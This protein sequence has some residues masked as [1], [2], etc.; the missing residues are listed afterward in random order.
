MMLSHPSVDAGLAVSGVYELAPIRGTGLNAKLQLKDEEIASLSPLR[1]PVVP[2][3]LA[4][5]YGAKE[6]PA[7]VGDSRS[8]HA[9]RVQQKASGPLIEIAGADHFTIL[10][11]L[12]K[13]HGHLVKAVLAL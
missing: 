7:L 4:I 11:E 9:L 13:P 12:E 6:L 2:K 8:L 10:D 1:L 5:A 3:A